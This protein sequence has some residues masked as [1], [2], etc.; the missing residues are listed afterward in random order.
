M[1]QLQHRNTK[2]QQDY[3][4]NGMSLEQLSQ[5]NQYRASDLK[6]HTRTHA[7]THKHTTHA[8]TQ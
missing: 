7:R 4:Q 1:E 5:Q 8:R 2:L 3:E 6:V